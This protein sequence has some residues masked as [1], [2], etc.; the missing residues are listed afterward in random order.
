MDSKRDADSNDARRYSTFNTE[1][2]G[3]GGC[4][5]DWYINGDAIL[6]SPCQVLESISAKARGWIQLTRPLRT[7]QPIDSDESNAIV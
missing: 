6:P 7:N 2:E 4:A 5:N 1:G 3:K